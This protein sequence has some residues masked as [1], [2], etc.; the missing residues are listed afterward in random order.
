MAYDKVY[1]TLTLANKQIFNTTDTIGAFEYTYNEVGHVTQ[2]IETYG[3]RNPPVVTETYNY[4]GLHRLIGVVADPIKNNGEKEIASYEYDAVGNRMKWASLTGL[5]SQTLTDGYTDTYAYNAAN[6][7][8]NVNV[9]SVRKNPN[10]N[11]LET[12][13]YDRNGSRINRLRVDENDKNALIEGVDYKSDPE[14]RMVEAS[15]YQLGGKDSKTRTDRAITTLKYDGGGRRLVNTY[16]PKSNA[17]QGVKKQ[18]QYVF[19]GLDPVSEYDMLVGNDKRDNFYRGA[20]GRITTMHD[21]KSGTQGQ[22]YWY[23]YNFKGDVVGLTK[24]NGNSTHNYRYDAYGSVIPDNGNFTDPHN[25]YTLTGKEFDENTG[26]IYFGARHYDARVGVWIG[27]DLYRGGIGQPMSLHRYGYV[28]NNPITYIDH[29]GLWAGI[30]DAIAIGAGALVGVVGQVVSD[31]VSMVT[32]GVVYGEW[33]V[34]FSEWQEYAGSAVAGAATGECVLYAAPTTGPGAFA[35]GAAGSAVGNLTKQGLSDKDFSYSDLAF[36]TAL[37]GGSSLIPAP[38]I[39]GITTSKG[40]FSAINKQMNTKF[41]RGLISNV[42]VSTAGKMFTS[43]VI[44]ETYGTLASSTVSGVQEGLC[45]NS[46][47]SQSIEKPIS[48][49]ATWESGSG[50]WIKNTPSGLMSIDPTRNQSLPIYNE[51]QPPPT[52]QQPEPIKSSPPVAPKIPKTYPPA[53][54]Y[55]NDPGAGAVKN[56]PG[57]SIIG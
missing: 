44:E 27:Q 51:P 57:Y 38:K 11:L 23:H 14:N 56:I 36:D 25:H 4:D 54:L 28:H 13:T 53:M 31:G 47:S 48:Q 22:M 43:Q 21:F 34:E 49:S 30:D 33:E 6:Q 46:E 39:K 50:L 9:D 8:L 20:G 5:S 15:D 24:Q 10:I 7:L 1:R 42:S 18:I 45:K 17:A 52:F 16:D 35:C 3:W 12:Y 2:T 41:Q 26:L 32:K 37:G 40:S 55:P 19:D 29:L